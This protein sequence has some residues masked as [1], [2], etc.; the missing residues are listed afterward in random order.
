MVYL[1][2]FLAV[3]ALDAL[4]KLWA[5]VAL[6]GAPSI[7]IW[8]KVFHLTYVE[9]RGAAFG[10]FQNGRAFFIVATIAVLLV[11]AFFA[12]RYKDKSKTLNFGFSLVASGAVG[13]LIDRVRLGFVVD[14]FD[15]CLI[16][17]PVFNVADIA[18]CIGAVCLAIFII[19]FEDTLKEKKDCQSDES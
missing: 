12:M 10:V 6:K 9:N 2:I 14:F 15:F 13:N 4:T 16:D 1:V 7:R 11:M 3:V 17:F 5:T 19:F 18:V 8:D